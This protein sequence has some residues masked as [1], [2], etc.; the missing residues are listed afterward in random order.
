MLHTKLLLRMWCSV[1]CGSTAEERWCS[2]FQ[3]QC[4]KVGRATGTDCVIR[5]SVASLDWRTEL[6]KAKDTAIVNSAN[7]PIQTQMLKY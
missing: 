3:G 7:I 6:N 1:V 5:I 4:Q 2:G